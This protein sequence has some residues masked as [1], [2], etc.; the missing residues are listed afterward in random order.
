MLTGLQN[1]TQN[2]GTR[3]GQ[4]AEDRTSEPDP[5]SPAG[6]GQFREGGAKLPSEACGARARGKG[7]TAKRE[8]PCGCE[9][10][11]PHHKGSTELQQV[12]QGH[13]ASFSDIFKN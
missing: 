4:L 12:P 7:R 1:T 6:K 2:G 9:E 13:G 8:V 3:L 11:V 10:R 5:F